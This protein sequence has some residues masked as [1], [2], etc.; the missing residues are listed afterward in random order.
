MLAV[1]G[2]VALAGSAVVAQTRYSPPG[3]T[4]PTTSGTTTTTTTT[5]T[6]TQTNPDPT[7]LTLAASGA[8]AAIG[9]VIRRRR[10]TP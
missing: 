7:G 6:P 3:T 10:G 2:L 5:T 4:S 8:A 1:T 9:Y